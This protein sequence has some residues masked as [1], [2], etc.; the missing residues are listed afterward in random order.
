MFI[1][2][3]ILDKWLPSAPSSG[4]CLWPRFHST[5]LTFW[6]SR[7]AGVRILW[8]C[9]KFILTDTRVRHVSRL[10]YVTLIRVL[11]SLLTGFVRW[12]LSP[13]LKGSRI[14][15]T[16]FCFLNTYS[17]S[18]ST[19][20]ESM[21]VSSMF[22]ISHETLLIHGSSKQAEHCFDRNN[23]EYVSRSTDII[24]GWTII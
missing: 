20:G 5:R 6:L 11:A 9:I 23:G 22:P 15:T 1:S 10:E 12:L 7:S 17:V 24:W 13:S 3:P 4:E 18:D 19:S 14:V 21:F 8:Q 2:L 16:G